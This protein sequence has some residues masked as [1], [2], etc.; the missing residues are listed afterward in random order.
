IKGPPVICEQGPSTPSSPTNS[1]LRRPNPLSSDAMERINVSTICQPFQK[2]ASL[3]PHS[4]SDLG[5]SPRSSISAGTSSC[6]PGWTGLGGSKKSSLE[7]DT[8]SDVLS[9]DLLSPCMTYSS[10]PFSPFSDCTEPPDTPHSI[11]GVSPAIS[12]NT[13]MK[14]L[15][16]RYFLDLK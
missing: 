12:P 2:F 14:S 7:C 1:R 13:S 5:S 10:A 15:H 8:D 9:K 16:F 3:S 4:T 6:S 11:F